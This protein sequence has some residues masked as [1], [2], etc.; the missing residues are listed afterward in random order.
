MSAP[1]ACWKCGGVL[2]PLRR[3]LPRR[4]QCRHCEAEL[5]VCRQCTLFNPQTSEHCDEPRAEHPRQ[6]DSA[7]FC[8][9]FRPSAKAYRA[10]K[11][12]SHAD[13]SALDT[14]FGGASA[15][16]TSASARDA[17]DDLF[18]KKE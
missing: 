3:P 16:A 13:K 18:K 7:N 8:D 15:P 14:L 5:H 2:P 17:L 12:A 6:L 11:S 9:Y 1:I 10:A 4:A